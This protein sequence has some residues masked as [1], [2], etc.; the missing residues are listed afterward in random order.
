MISNNS[1]V[2]ERES[3]A[4]ESAAHEENWMVIVFDNDFTPYLS[5]VQI[6]MQATGCS[7]EEASIET[8]EVHNLGK[9]TVHYASEKECE[10]VAA[11]IRSIGIEVEVCPEFVPVN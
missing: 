6:L 8:W 3:T 1:T 9:S 4:Q 2:I 11:T 5:V 7:L 10:R